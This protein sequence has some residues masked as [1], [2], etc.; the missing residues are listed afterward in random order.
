MADY[1]DPKVTTH[2]DDK[3][4]RNSWIAIAIG[5]IIL[6]AL[7]WWWLSGDEV[8]PVAPVVTGDGAAVEEL[9]GEGEVDVEVVPVEPVAPAD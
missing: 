8:E 2:R 1:R 9:E 6:I 4:K 5:V 3:K 7:L